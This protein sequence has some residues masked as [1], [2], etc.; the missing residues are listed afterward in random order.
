MN[1]NKFYSLLI[2]GFCAVFTV[3]AQPVE[4]F[5]KVVV[6]P[7]HADWT[8]KTGEPVK[9]SIAVLKDGNL[10]K[11]AIVKYE[12]G[13]EKMDALKKDSLQLKDGKLTVDAQGMKTP[14]F[15][16]CTVSAFVDGK[17]YKYW[18]TAAFDPLKIEPTV[19]DPSDFNSFWDSA[20]IALAK[21]PI[22]SR[23]TLIP[24]K[25]TDLVNVYHVS[26]QNINNSRVYGILCVPKK[27]GK[28]PAILRV[29]GAG[30]R[31]YNGD[32]RNAS[33]GVITLEI[34]IHGIPVNMP[35]D[36]Y[37]NLASGAL[38]GYQY[39]NLDNRDRFYYKRVFLGCV[40][41]ND[42]I[43]SLPEFDGKNLAVAGGSQGGALSIITAALD[44]RVKYLAAFYP[45][46]S[47]MTGYL[48]NRAGGWPHLF[49]K[50]N[51]Q[52]NNK[53][54]KIQTV[55]YYDVVN[56]AKRLKATGFYSWGFN[57]NVCPPTSMYAAYNVINAPKSLLLAVETAHWAYPEQT[58][59]S[60]E[61][62]INKL[63]G[64]N[65]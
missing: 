29:P 57:D 15:L 53:K 14:G 65:K 38:N 44:P 33:K 25:C 8:Y 64:E 3:Q 4:Q 20:K 47:D 55:A 28:Y 39:F 58:E 6:A 37:N 46:M 61:W 23:M 31:P 59:K 19:D 30:I 41:A 11:N 9:F 1:F 60:E 12:V 56:F 54:D 52:Y 36:V 34:G 32:I 63:K 62:L 27:P 22:D 42:F 2:I 5:V 51:E 49:D 45:A 26:F 48:K 13:P 18:S 43:D 10:L 17:E 50:N 24:E 40:R 7:D 16:R 21:I 35:I